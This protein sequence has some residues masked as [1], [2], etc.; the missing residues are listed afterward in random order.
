MKHFRI[1]LTA[2]AVVLI[3]ATVAV[4]AADKKAKKKAGAKVAATVTPAGPSPSA[5]QW[6][7]ADANFHRDFPVMALD[8]TGTAWIAYIEHDGKADVLRLARKTG[9]GLE[10][11]VTLSEP[12]VI[13]QPAITCDASGAVWSFWGQVDARNVVTLRARRFAGGRLDPPITLAQSAGSDTFADTGADDRGRVW[14]VWQSLR[15]GQGDIFARWLDP[16]S[17]KWSKEIAASKPEGG[18]WEPRVAFDGKEGAWVV[19]DS[20]RGGEFNLYLAHVGLDGRV[21]EHQLRSSPEYEARASVTAAKDGSGL[22]IAAERGRRQWG[23]PLRGHEGDTGL[24]GLKRFLLGHYDI[25][26]EKFT[27]VPV[28][29]DGKPAPRTAVCVNLPTLATDA[30]G[31]PW[32]AYRFYFQNRWMI[33]VT[34]YDAKAKAWSQPMEVPDSSFGQDRRCTLARDAAGRMLLCWA[35]DKRET[36]LVL[37]AGVF[38]AQLEPAFT[39][40]KEP[41]VK[42][43]ML[44]EPEPYLNQPTP[45]RPREQ[46]HTWNLGGK[47][48]TL[49]FGDLHRHTDFSNCRTGFDGCVLEHFRYAYDMAALDF[50]G[51]SDHTDIAK[52]YDPYEWWQTQRLVDVFYAPGKFN[53]LYAYEREQKYPWGHRNVVFAQRGGPIVYINRKLYEASPWT[54]LYPVHPGAEH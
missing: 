52:K 49:V 1:R 44:A 37:V 47:K 4:T 31:N 10:N 26:A 27:E 38:L 11:V 2:L 18:N 9:N 13:H 14:V 12:G 48:Y 54:A 19:F 34:K 7:L 5:A 53:S 23:K 36:K 22:W 20:S 30:D 45:D 3:C 32:I 46:H 51:T 42:V 40:I 35:S 29:D 6:T 28:P 25:A 43:A 8:A 21:K 17:G 33:A 24:N 41:A 39:P 16:K 50:M 15:R